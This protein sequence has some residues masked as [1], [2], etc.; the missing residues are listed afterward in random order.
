MMT[1]SAVS[2]LDITMIRPLAPLPERTDEGRHGNQD[3]SWSVA[4]T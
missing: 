1:A 4:T 3:Y 2:G